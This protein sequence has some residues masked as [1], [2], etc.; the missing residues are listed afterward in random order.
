MDPYCL[1]IASSRTNPI[2]NSN[3]ISMVTSTS[4]STATGVMNRVVGKPTNSSSATETRLYKE[5]ILSE[6]FYFILIVYMDILNQ[7][8]NTTVPS[9]NTN[10]SST[11]N[12]GTKNRFNDTIAH[13]SSVLAQANE[14]FDFFKVNML[15]CYYFYY[16]VH[17]H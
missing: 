12:T 13:H 11:N 6:I 4:T 7:L 16:Y 15:F 9:T 14:E 2:D 17:Y 3:P 10:A 8:R 5:H 1:F